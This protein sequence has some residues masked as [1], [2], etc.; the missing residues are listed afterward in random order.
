LGEGGH[1]RPID[2]VAYVQEDLPIG[3]AVVENAG[4]QGRGAVAARARSVARL[5]GAVVETIARRDGRAVSRQGIDFAF[6]R[7]LGEEQAAETQMRGQREQECSVSSHECLLP[8]LG[9]RGMSGVT[10]L[11]RMNRHVPLRFL[12]HHGPTICVPE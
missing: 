8:E 6:Q 10:I 9:R 7:V 4:G 12:G 2:A 3:A 5:A 1:G 11:Q